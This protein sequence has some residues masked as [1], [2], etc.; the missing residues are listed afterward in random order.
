MFG[1]LAE[2]ERDIIRERT[3]AGLTAARARG[4]FG[5]RPRKMDT[6]KV[7]MAKSLLEN[8]QNSIDDVCKT[9][10]VSRATLYRYLNDEKGQE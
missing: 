2:F 5:G 3:R 1:A 6:K 7:S 8:P 9:L 10:K 4:R